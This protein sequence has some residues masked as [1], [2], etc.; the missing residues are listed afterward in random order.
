[1]KI[2]GT[3]IDTSYLGDGAYYLMVE[4][5]VPDDD[6]D[7]GYRHEVLQ[8]DRPLCNVKNTVKITK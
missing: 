6:F 4:I 3:L 7:D 2:S 1:M 5:D 8:M